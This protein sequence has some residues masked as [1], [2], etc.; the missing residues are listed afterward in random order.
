MRNYK[1]ALLFCGTLFAAHMAQAEL[2]QKAELETGVLLPG[3]SSLIDSPFTGVATYG[4]GDGVELE[5]TI[6]GVPG[7]FRLDIRGASSNSSSAGISVYLGD[8]KLGQVGFSGTT[9]SLKSLEFSLEQ[10]P[11]SSTMQFVLESDTGANDTFVDWYELHRVGDI[12][13]PPPPPVLPDQGA[14]ES[15]VYRNLFEEMGI[16]Q[17][18]VDARV[19]EVYDQ[20]FH[21]PDQENEAIFIPVGDDMA[22]IWDV[23]ND[24]V[25][26][27]GMSYGMMMAVQL[28]RKDDFDR[29]WKWANTYSLN[30]EGDMKGY[31]AWQVNT[32]GQVIDKNPAPDGEEYFATALFFASHLWGDGEG[33]FNYSAQANQILDDMYN[34]GQTRYANG[35]ELEYISLFDHEQMQITF[36]P[37]TPT[38]RN[39]TDPSY[40]LPAFYE[41][42]ARWADDNNAFWAEL[43]ESSRDFFQ[44][45]AHA[46]TGLSPDYAYFDGRP[47]GDFQHWKDTFQYDAWRTIGNA[48]MDYSWWQKD[49]WQVTWANRLQSFFESEGVDSYSSLYELD[50]VPYENNSDHSPGLV[51]MNA[52]ASLAADDQRAWKFVRALWDTP[53][54]T[55]KYRYYDGCLYLFGMLHVSGKFNIICPEGECDF[56]Q[57]PSCEDTNSCPSNAAPV[58][59]DDTL[60]TSAGVSAGI[61]VLQNDADADGDM[62]EVVSFTQGGNGTVTASGSQLTYSPNSGFS[63]PDSFSYT[64]S[65]GTDTDTA[66]VAVTV[67]AADSND[68]SGDDGAVDE[69]EGDDGSQEE[70][71][72]DDDTGASTLLGKYEFEAGLISPSYRGPMTSPYSG[73]TLYGN[74]DSVEFSVDSLPA[75]QYSVLVS[76]SSTNTTAAGISLYVDGVAHGQTAFNSTSREVKQIDFELTSAATTITFVLETDVGQNDTLLDWF[77]LYTG[78]ATSAEPANNESEEGGEPSGGENTAAGA[79]VLVEAEDYIDYSDSTSGNTGGAYR[80]DDVDIETTSDVSGDHNVGWIAAGE[81]LEY[82][83]DLEE[84]TYVVESRVASNSSDGS[85]DILLDGSHVVPNQGVNSTGGW[86]NWHTISSSAFYVPAGTY[87]LRV[88]MTGNY[89]NLNWLRFVPQ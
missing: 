44:T 60:Q 27:E 80:N 84:G 21:S 69:G 41:L 85:F 29:L 52:V 47:H 23:G 75:G 43:A 42:W 3:Y 61:D 79:E 56:T 83:V 24:D 53:V 8:K 22:Y 59:Q 76:G 46:Q 1:K 66:V 74:G 87:T 36:S 65:D 7:E 64:V 15:G 54:P 14:Y 77:E 33:I 89:F 82:D 5:T 71:N 45:T 49:P 26:S 32:D 40:H 37:A 31:F 13:P 20:L 12:P 48:A 2:L 78:D 55:G 28:G 10:Y 58:A 62:L 25:R 67:A 86:Q 70:G 50:G 73:V 38:D 17:A 9:P 6:S 11:E 39:W 16:S 19:Q 88:S 18:E 81:W 72:G 34:N 51:A 4:N 57:P 63:G 35:G 30:K 68:G